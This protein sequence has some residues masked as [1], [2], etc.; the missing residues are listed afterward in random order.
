MRL[1]QNLPFKPEEKEE[2]KIIIQSNIINSMISLI[3]GAI[4]QK[5]DLLTENLVIVQEF[6][7]YYQEN[8]K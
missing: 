6:N 5:K 1:N 4:D 3:F 7:K 8:F 2:A